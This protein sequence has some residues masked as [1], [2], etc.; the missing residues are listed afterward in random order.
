MA[1]SHAARCTYC[2]RDPPH[3]APPSTHPPYNI[4][5]QFDPEALTKDKLKIP[6]D[7]APGALLQ[8]LAAPPRTQE[9]E[10]EEQQDGEEG[11]EDTYEVRR[12]EDSECG[13]YHVLVQAA[14]EVA[15]VLKVGPPITRQIVVAQRPPQT[16]SSAG[17]TASEPPPR[18]A[19]PGMVVPYVPIAQ[20]E[21]MEVRF[22]PPGA[23]SGPPPP[24]TGHDDDDDEEEEDDESSPKKKK[25]DKRGRDEEGAS[26]AEKAKKKKE[27]RRK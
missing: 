7:A 19:V 20:V 3:L 23:G 12:G 25:K 2:P 8:A 6:E 14:G 18:P 15:G 11:T 4:H 9:G 21:G 1:L 5:P 16:P 24:L 27:K 22:K 17:G 10:E 26:S 13:A